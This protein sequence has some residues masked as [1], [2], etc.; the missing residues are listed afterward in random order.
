MARENL[1]ATVLG[2][3]G[4]F[5]VFAVLFYFAGV[6]ELVD[7][8]RMADA[9]TV[10]LVVLA[11]LA[12]L[13]AW[14]LALRTVLGV[15]GVDLSFPKSFFVFSGAMFSNNITPFGQAGGEP[16][17]AY[18]IS[19]SA[20]AEYETSLAAIASVDTLNFV[21]SITI[22]L[23]GALYYATEI[24]LGTNRDLV[25]ALV[26]VVVLA[27]TVPSLGYVAWQRRYRLEERVVSA[28]TPAIRWVAARAPRI[29]VPTEGGIE[30]R[31]NGFFR[32]IERVATNPR[33]LALALG[34][35]AFGWFCQMLGL[36]LSFR[37]IGIQI[38]LSIA[39][40][41]VP[42]GAIA[43]V[44]PLPGGAGG[45]ESVLVVLL[46]AAPLPA[47]TKSIAVAAIVIF[48]GAVYW[49][50]TLLGGGVMAWVSFRDST[51]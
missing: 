5:A 49:V 50:P 26:A 1:R 15:L 18:L 9:G 14:S 8:L 3:L 24:T 44:T 45:I 30:R 34:A 19:Q 31:I 7:T 40:L 41:V 11:T 43:G 4:A 22:A 48:R 17:T 37:A 32:A 2:F 33:G 39:M 38:P 23:V 47:V 12:W 27:V 46:L 25:L 36:W 51:A 16:V 42:I 29:P 10:G 35:S 21:P 28:F 20:D 6:G 13:A